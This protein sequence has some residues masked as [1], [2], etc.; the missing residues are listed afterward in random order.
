MKVKKIDF[1]S[2]HK[3]KKLLA[4]H[5]KMNKYIIFLL[6]FV[7]SCKNE[8]SSKE[9]KSIG[10]NIIEISYINNNIISS[11]TIDKTSKKILVEFYYN[12]KGIPRLVKEFL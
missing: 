3:I 7:L 2:I 5:Y 10:N 9:V 4:E 1:T 8:N 11:K 12:E 6:T